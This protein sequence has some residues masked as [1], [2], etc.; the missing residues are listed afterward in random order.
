MLILTVGAMWAVGALVWYLTRFT[1]RRDGAA[2]DLQP[3]HV[4]LKQLFLSLAA[5]WLTGV[6]L[7][8]TQAGVNSA[9]SSQA[10]ISAMPASAVVPS[11]SPAPILP[12][13]LSATPLPDTGPASNAESPIAVDTQV[14][15]SELRPESAMLPASSG[16]GGATSDVGPASSPIV[17]VEVQKK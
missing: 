1:N 10:T 4:Y 14:A 15:P 5:M 17:E 6:L 3:A 9:P 8:D 12:P 16:L 2:I 7:I 11:A 13:A